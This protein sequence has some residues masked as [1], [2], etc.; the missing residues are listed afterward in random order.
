MQ[1]KQK[2][3]VAL[4]QALEH[5]NYKYYIENAPEISDQQFDEMMHELEKLE[6]EFPELYG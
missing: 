5:H 4:R 1:T 3:I 2:R 6:A